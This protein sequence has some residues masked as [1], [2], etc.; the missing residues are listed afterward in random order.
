MT[1]GN[2]KR[3]FAEEVIE[4]MFTDENSND[5]DLDCGIIS[6]TQMMEQVIEWTQ[7]FIRLTQ[8]I[9][10]VMECIQRFVRLTQAIDPGVQK[11]DGQIKN[12]LGW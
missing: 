6:L 2:K 12:Y 11:I 8:M 3:F 9:E 4:A 7:R 10:Q 5:E 1:E